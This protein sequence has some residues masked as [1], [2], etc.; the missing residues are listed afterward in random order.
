MLYKRLTGTVVPG[1]P[2]PVRFYEVSEVDLIV[3]GNTLT[4]ACVYRR[5]EPG[6]RRYESA[7]VVSGQSL[8]WALG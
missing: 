8:R 1:S 3:V 5:L 7:I 6:V 4:A 2:N